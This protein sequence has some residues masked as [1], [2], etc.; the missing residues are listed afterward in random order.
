MYKLKNA[1]SKRGTFLPDSLLYLC[2]YLMITYTPQLVTI[3][4]ACISKLNLKTLY[5]L[6]ISIFK[7]TIS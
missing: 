3:K 1:S 7:L 6:P 2:L 5:T 4:R